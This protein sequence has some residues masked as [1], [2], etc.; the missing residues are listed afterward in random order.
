MFYIDHFKIPFSILYFDRG[1]AARKEYNVTLNSDGTPNVDG[2][3]VSNG[4]SIPRCM[5]RFKE[6]AECLKDGVVPKRDFQIKYSKERLE[7]LN[8]SR[9]LG[10]GQREEFDKNNDLDLGDWQCSYC[11]FK[12]YCW[13]GEG[14]NA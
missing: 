3:K 1:N 6:L 2:K 4:L 8:A 10:K 12:D 11:S 7:L 9:R 13:T 5:S 14:K